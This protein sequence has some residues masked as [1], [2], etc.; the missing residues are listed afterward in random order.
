M[1]Y[2]TLSKK[3]RDAIDWIGNRYSHGNDLFRALNNCQLHDEVDDAG[4]NWDD[5]V[6][7]TF[8]IPESL[9]WEISDI[10]DSDDLACFSSE[11]RNKLYEFQANIV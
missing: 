1:Y 9:A 2:L 7:L 5:E 8:S 10:I 4:W 6:S 3:D 11:L